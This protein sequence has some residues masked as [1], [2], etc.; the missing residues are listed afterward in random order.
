[1]TFRNTTGPLGHQAVVFLS[2]SN[3]SAV[4]EC[5]IE[6]YLGTLFTITSPQIYIQ[7]QIYGTTDFIFGA[8]QAMFQ[9]S[10]N[11]LRKPTTQRKVGCDR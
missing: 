4:Y 2:A 11:F 5:S 3:T 7:C 6:G 1:M 8:N 10:D 9:D